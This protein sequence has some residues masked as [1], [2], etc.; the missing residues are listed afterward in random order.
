MGELGDVSF[1]SS[2]FSPFS[3]C[4]LGGGMRGGELM[5]TRPCP[6]VTKK[7]AP[8]QAGFPTARPVWPKKVFGY[9]VKPGAVAEDAPV[10]TK[11]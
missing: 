11:A 2:P 9:D 5:G 6:T 10:R 1:F 7:I 4:I 8:G 3:H